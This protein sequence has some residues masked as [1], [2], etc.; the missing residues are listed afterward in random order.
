MQHLTPFD[1]FELYIGN[2]EAEGYV[3][4]ATLK[5]YRYG[6]SRFLSD[7]TPPA[8]CHE[9]S[10]KHALAW[11]AALRKRG[12]KPGAIRT[13]QSA[14]WIWFSWLH[15]EG[16]TPHDIARQVRRTRPDETTVTRR[17]ATDDV[18]EKL[19]VVAAD[20]SE[21]KWR[22]RAL[23]LTLAAT[24]ARRAELAAC[25]FEDYQAD[26]GVLRLWRHT[27]THEERWCGVDA[28][29]RFALLQYFKHERG[30]K[31]G[32]LFLQRMAQPM[33]A[34]AITCVIR[35]LAESAGVA[36]SAHDFRRACAARMLGAGALPDV[37]QYQLGHRTAS[38]TLMYGKEARRD[39][40]VREYHELDQGV[41]R[42]R[43]SS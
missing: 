23:L 43:K 29:A 7:I 16:Y 13:Y 33:S 26:P 30:E 42:L 35:S 6:I 34:N 40:S 38:L 10:G 5:F 2:L 15:R 36:C 27:K 9:L 12:L 1:A 28:Q 8:S 11:T 3:R 19:L 31:A 32:P 37:V 17:T 41:R 4:E 20:R 22:N 39:R 21:W 14:V 18:I 25:H 24:G